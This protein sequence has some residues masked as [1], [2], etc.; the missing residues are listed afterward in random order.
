MDDFKAPTATEG[1]VPPNGFEKTVA[2]TVIA[3]IGRS[4]EYSRTVG[5]RLGTL[6]GSLTYKDA[7]LGSTIHSDFT[8]DVWIT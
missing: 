3:T 6:L 2:T 7:Q 1:N 8:V 4:L 5:T